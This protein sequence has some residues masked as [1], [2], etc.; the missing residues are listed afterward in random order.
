MLNTILMALACAL[1]LPAAAQ[2]VYKCTLDGKVSYGE[3]PC[4]AGKADL[5]A[6]PAAPPPDPHAQRELKR[7]EALLAKLQ[8]ERRATEARDQRAQARAARAA[9]ARKQR[10]DKLR[11][12]TKWADEDLARS[13][14]QARGAA[15]LKAQRQADAMAV[16][17]PA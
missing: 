1:C 10:C 11:L 7:Q 16:E 2:T 12:Q 3:T 4:A 15:R 14:S 5:L 9:A 8:Q 17:C 6:V 13:G